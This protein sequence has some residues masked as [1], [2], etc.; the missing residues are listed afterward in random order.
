MTP[1][2]TFATLVLPRFKQKPREWL[3]ENQRGVEVSLDQLLNSGISKELIVL[4]I[5][6]VPVIEL[7][8][9]IP[10]GINLFHFSWYYTLLLAIIGNMLPVPFILLFLNAL[11]R[12]LSRIPVMERMFNWLFERTRRR[13]KIVE[14]YERV[15]LA[16]FVAVPLP[17]TG[18]WTASLIA[19]MLGMNFKYALLAIFAGVLI[20]GAIVTSLS[21]LGWVGAAIAGITLGVLAGMGLWKMRPGQNQTE[22]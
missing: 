10:V 4:I 16:L 19:V 18:A 13:G 6:A 21:L 22:G 9:A 12:L 15:G 3:P 1:G 8:G 2:H 17:M 7:R 11:T 5:S 14:R 20:A